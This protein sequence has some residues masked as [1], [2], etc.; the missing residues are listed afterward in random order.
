MTIQYTHNFKSILLRSAINLWPLIKVLLEISKDL[1]V[2]ICLPY[3]LSLPHSKVGMT[4][5]CLE[6]LVFY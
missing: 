5:S 1:Q 4:F 3:H 6:I 2:L